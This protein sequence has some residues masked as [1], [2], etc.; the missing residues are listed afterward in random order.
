MKLP[1]QTQATD[2]HVQATRVALQFASLARVGERPGVECSRES[3]ESTAGDCDGR[4]S[5]PENA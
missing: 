2:P 5:R 1:S 3:M 4:F